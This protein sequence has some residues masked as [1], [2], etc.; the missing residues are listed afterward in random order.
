MN[1]NLLYRLYSGAFIGVCL[2]PAVLMPFVKADDSKENRILSQAPKIKNEDGSYSTTVTVNGE[3]VE[4]QR[5]FLY[6]TNKR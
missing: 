3:E 4:L 1:K 6:D 5:L 2:L